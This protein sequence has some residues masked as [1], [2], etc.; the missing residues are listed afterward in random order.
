MVFQ[1]FGKVTRRM[2]RG[3]RWRIQMQRPTMCARRRES[4]ERYPRRSAQVTT[5]H[6]PRRYEDV[7]RFEE[8]FL[9]GRNEV[10]SC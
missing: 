4:K 2:E 5:D 10:R 8:E 7:Q 9:V 1:S 3:P 6:S